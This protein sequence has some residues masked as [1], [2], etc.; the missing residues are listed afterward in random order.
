MNTHIYTETVI[1]ASV[2]EV[3]NILAAFERYPEWNPFVRKVEGNKYSG[4]RLVVTIQPP[5][6]HATIFNPTLITFE[7]EHEIR[8]LGRVLTRGLFDGEH[9]LSLDPI[10]D[11]RVRFVHQEMFSGILVPLFW[12]GIDVHTRAGFKAMN[13][14]LKKLAESGGLPEPKPTATPSVLAGDLPVDTSPQQNG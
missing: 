13:K 10:D 3:W 8:W 1:N 5:G 11:N 9:V 4:S 7:P 2:S 14:A 6:K 12:G